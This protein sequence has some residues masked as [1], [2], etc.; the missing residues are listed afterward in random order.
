MRTLVPLLALLAA[1]AVAEDDRRTIELHAADVGRLALKNGPAYLV[2]EIDPSIART[3]VVEALG[4]FDRLFTSH[5]GFGGSREE[6]FFNVSSFGSP[7][8]ASRRTPTVS[9][10]HVAAGVG[11]GATQEWGGAWKLGY[12]ATSTDRRGDASLSSFEPR[13]DGELTG[14]YRHPLLRGAGNDQNLAPV[15]AARRLVRE[16]ELSLEREAELTVERAEAAYWDLVGAKADRELKRKSLDVARELLSVVRARVDSGRGIPVDVTEALAGIARREVDL[17]AADNLVAN[18]GDRLR[19]LVLPF[20]GSNPDLELEI[21]AADAPAAAVTSSPPAPGLPEIA[22]AV[23]RRADVGAAQARLDAAQIEEDRANAE[24]GASLDAVLSAGLTGKGSGFS[25]SGSKFWHRRAYSW[26]AGIELSLPLGDRA[27][28]SR[29][30]RARRQRERSEREMTSL[31]NAVVRELR[32]ASRNVRS[33]ADRIEAAARAT[34][35]A[36]EQLAAEKSR[37]ESGRATP[38]DVLQSEEELTKAGAA[39][40]QARVDWEKARVEVLRASGT[41]LGTRG[42]SGAAAGE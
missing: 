7:G 33:A 21:V 2:R 42:L 36:T 8:S 13:Y 32:E 23:S 30:L 39:E 6:A 15:R 25:E 31:R 14:T 37:L 27:A 12:D 40:V 4:A 26:D 28:T 9:E 22:D 19:E 35:A 5:A 11:V 38:F 17:I 18:A 34:A 41:L 16:S 29:A 20:D 10:S 3:R 24:T 1:A